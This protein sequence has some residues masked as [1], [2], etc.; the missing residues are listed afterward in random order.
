MI[1]DDTLESIFDALKNAAIAKRD[2]VTLNI[3]FSRLRPRGDIISSVQKPAQGVV[4]FLKIFNQALSGVNEGE[5]NSKTITIIIKVNHPD[6]LEFL[7]YKSNFTT[8]IEVNSDFINAVENNQMYDLID[9]RT[10]L[11]TNKL[12]AQSVYNLISDKIGDNHESQIL[13]SQES[14][15]LS[16]PAITRQAR[17]ITPPPIIKMVSR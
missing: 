17:E 7:S 12:S 2:G 6:I 16:Y 10:G 3:D 15:P 4:A 5:N 1:I 14:L 8:K 9:P 11:A 13:Y